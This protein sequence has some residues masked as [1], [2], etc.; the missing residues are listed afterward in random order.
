MKTDLFNIDKEI[1]NFK[2]IKIEN[3]PFINGAYQVIKSARQIKKTSP[4]ASLDLPKLFECDADI[5]ELAVLGSKKALDARVWVDLPLVNKKEILA[6]FISL[7]EKNMAELAYLDCIETG[8]SYK[9]FVEDSIPK[10]IKVARWF[11]ECSDKYLDH[12]INPS[13]RQIN[14]II[15]EPIGVVGIIVPW[16]D[17]LVVA[18]WK[19]MPALIMGN[20][21]VMKPAEQSSFSMIKLAMLF[22]NAGLPAGVLNV[23][24]G[25]GEVTGDALVKNTNISAIFFTGSSKTAKNIVANSSKNNLK[26]LSI[27]CGG[28]SAFIVSKKCKDLNNAAEVLAKSIFYN[29]G[30]IC[31][32]PSRLIIEKS[33]KFKFIKF[34]IKHTHKYL[35][36]HPF[37][38]GANVGFLI[39]AKHKRMIES[40]IKIGKS[41][42]EKSIDFK[43]Y[44]APELSSSNCLAPII[45]LDPPS[46]SKLISE[47]IFGPI[48]TVTTFSSF[49]DAIVQANNSKYGLAASIWTEDINEALHG[50]RLLQAGIVHINDYGNDDEA[51]PFGGIKDSGFGKDKSIF[52]FDEYSYTKSI[53]I[54]LNLK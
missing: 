31:S 41:H 43:K 45:F 54:R 38:S 7:L 22:K 48:L 13:V 11:L 10:A 37:D 49:K 2:K 40:Y 1:F 16:N 20:S 33:I 4:I 5:V 9:N 35:P 25:R 50:A 27:E 24:T 21:V 29:Q 17:P 47:E 19:V 46:K 39:S 26:R 15:K 6:A 42:S 30:Q 12:S 14:H 53:C 44:L 52:A 18:L 28:K 34:L 23:I 36:K 8:R 51:V 32:A 3:R